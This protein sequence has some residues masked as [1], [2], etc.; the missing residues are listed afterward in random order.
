MTGRKNGIS[1]PREQGER[2]SK[3]VQE[4]SG[5]GVVKATTLSL[6]IREE[7]RA[8]KYRIELWRRRR[9]RGW[10]YEMSF[11]WNV[12]QRNKVGSW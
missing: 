12:S 4:D 11:H 1:M 9:R 3:V 5:M 2:Q 8:K 7:G 6:S 10:F